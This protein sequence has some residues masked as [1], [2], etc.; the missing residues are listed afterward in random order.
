MNNLVDPIND[1]INDLEVGEWTS[2]QHRKDSSTLLYAFLVIEE[3]INKSV[4]DPA[5]PVE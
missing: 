3:A 5:W 4:V 2:M 1:V